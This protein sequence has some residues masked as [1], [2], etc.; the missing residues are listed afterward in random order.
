MVTV[1]VNRRD[2][3]TLLRSATNH[4]VWEVITLRLVS[5]FSQ[6]VIKNIQVKYPDNISNQK[7]RYGSA[8]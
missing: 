7:I 6:I 8:E 4:E 5:W 3:D 1:N 2:R